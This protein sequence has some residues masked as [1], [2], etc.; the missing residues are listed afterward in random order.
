MWWLYTLHNVWRTLSYITL[1]KY[2][3]YLI[4]TLLMYKKFYRRITV[5]A[6][7]FLWEDDLIWCGVCVPLCAIGSI[8][9]NRCLSRCDLQPIT[10]MPWIT[11]DTACHNGRRCPSSW[12][13]PQYII[14]ISGVS[15]LGECCTDS[16]FCFS[17]LWSNTFNVNYGW[18]L[19]SYLLMS[20]EVACIGSLSIYVCIQNGHEGAPLGTSK[21]STPSVMQ[22]CKG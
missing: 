10:N 2:V 17:S 9:A 14:A 22:R 21:G 18:I 15:P 16:Y 19:I 7:D 13:R 12:R 11:S 3:H 1:S 6:H 20:I 8:A 4:C 5:L